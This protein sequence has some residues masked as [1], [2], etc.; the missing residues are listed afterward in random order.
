MLWNP[1]PR[2]LVGILRGVSGSGGLCCWI[3]AD[4]GGCGLFTIEC[5]GMTCYWYFLVFL[6]V[7][8]LSIRILVFN[9]YTI[10]HN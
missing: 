1:A 2:I 5:L 9:I 3:G 6:L 7:I 8:I 4:V 10:I